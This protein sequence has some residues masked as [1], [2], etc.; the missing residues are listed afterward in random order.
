[1]NALCPIGLVQPKKN[2]KIV[3]TMRLYAETKELPDFAYK[4][5]YCIGCGCKNDLNKVLE[6]IRNMNLSVFTDANTPF[7]DEFMPNEQAEFVTKECKIGYYRDE[8]NKLKFITVNDEL[9]DELIS[10]SLFFSFCPD[11]G[12]IWKLYDDADLDERISKRFAQF[13]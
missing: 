3:D 10:K 11:C 13:V 8:D 12:R 7:D 6:C 5:D 2:I 1:M 4:F 9:T